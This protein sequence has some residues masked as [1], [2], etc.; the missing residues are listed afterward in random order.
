MGPEAW[1]LKNNPQTGDS[2]SKK[3]THL[4]AFFSKT[5]FELK[6]FSR[7]CLFLSLSLS[8]RKLDWLFCMFNYGVV[9]VHLFKKR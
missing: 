9:C 1:M 2:L 8:L 6:A 7:T 5:I 3:P 4:F